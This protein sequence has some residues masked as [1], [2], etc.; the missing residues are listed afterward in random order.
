MQH[1]GQRK[2]N[3][4]VVVTGIG[5]HSCLGTG[6][7]EVSESLRVGRSGIV[8]DPTRLEHGFR[9]ALTGRLPE[10]PAG[11]LNRKMRRTMCEP[12]QFGYAAAVAAIRDA[13]LEDSQIRND[14]CGLIFGND[15][16]VGA[17]V[18][19]VDIARETG[20][21]HFMG[22]GHIFRSMNSTVS[23]NLASI[24]GVRGANWT[25]SAACASGAHAV[26]QAAAMIRA[27]LQDTV[28]AGGAQETNWQSMASFDAL[29]VFSMRQDDP[30]SACRPFDRHRDG[31]VPSGGSACLVLE[32]EDLARRRGAHIYARL[33]GY[34]FASD[35]NRHLSSPSTDAAARVMRN[36]LADAG[37]AADEIE[38]ANA[39]ATGTPIGDRAEAGGIAEVLGGDVPVS[40]TKSLTGHECWAAGAT[41]LI[42]TILMARDGFL[43]GNANF[44]E[45][46][47]DGPRINVIGQSREQS[48]RMAL[49]NSFGFGG[50]NAALILEFGM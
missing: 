25:L 10:L 42:Y 48:I 32:R 26:G 29:G 35:G 49:S 45:L 33:R 4:S 38:Y 37:V 47:E 15:T 50:T 17:S 2:G 43:A 9:S 46:D 20:M 19:A 7:E 22:S 3:E 41:E 16:T 21:T 6:L 11:L 18:E 27:G 28:L 39:H 36:A 14:R 23:M 1:L 40:S 30:A 24:L 12:A 44:T 8:N 31:L 5:L 13:G 34:G